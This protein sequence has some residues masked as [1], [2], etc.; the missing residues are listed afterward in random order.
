MKM[1]KMNTDVMSTGQWCLI[2]LSEIAANGLLEAEFDNAD[3]GFS[4][5]LEVVE[6]SDEEYD[7][8]PEFEG[9]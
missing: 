7:A 4:V 1:L 3:P 5:R 8:L 2:P 9:P 6:I